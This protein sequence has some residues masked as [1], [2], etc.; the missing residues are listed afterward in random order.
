MDLSRSFHPRISSTH[1]SRSLMT[2]T[3]ASSK[4]TA[5]ILLLSLVSCSDTIISPK[6]DHSVLSLTITTYRHLAEVQS[7]SHR[8]FALV[9]LVVTVSTS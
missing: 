4:K 3:R 5:H 9:V 7:T 8:Q 1:G 2:A 6:D